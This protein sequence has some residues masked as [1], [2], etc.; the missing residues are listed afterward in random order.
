[1]IPTFLTL[2]NIR[3]VSRVKWRNPGKGVGASPTLRCT[4]YWKRCLLVALGNG[5]QIYFTY[6][7]VLR[8]SQNVILLR[9][10]FQLLYVSIFS[11]CLSFTNLHILGRVKNICN[12][13]ARTCLW[14]V[15]YM[16]EEDGALKDT[17]CGRQNH[18]CWCTDM[19]CIA[20]LC[21]WFECRT[22]ECSRKSNSVTYALWVRTGT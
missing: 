3:Y 20:P 8:Y 9:S 15:Y 11:N 6:Y 4:S 12:I 10:V 22:D 16:T 17:W 18:G 5:R 21:M 7:V 14:P 19:L 1:M 2:S 13:L